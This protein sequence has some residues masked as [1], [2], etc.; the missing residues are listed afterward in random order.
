MLRLDGIFGREWDSVVY[1]CQGYSREVRASLVQWA[2]RFGGFVHIEE[3]NK[4][5]FLVE[6]ANVTDSHSLT[7][8]STGWAWFPH[9]YAS[10]YG[11]HGFFIDHAWC[12]INHYRKMK[13]SQQRGEA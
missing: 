13:R 11:L 7:V 4:K 6:V 1:D 10:A 5:S 8:P 9:R 3:G 12:G 2:A